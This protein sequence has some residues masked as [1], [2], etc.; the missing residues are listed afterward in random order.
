MT[1]VPRETPKIM[2]VLG[3]AGLLPFVVTAVMMARAAWF[4]EGLQSAA[5]GGFYVPYIFIAYSAV[6][7]SFL[8]GTL[9]SKWTSFQ[10]QGLSGLIIVSSNAVALISW[11]ALLLIYLSSLATLLALGLLVSGFLSLM[12]LERFSQNMDRRYWQLRVNLTIA[13]TITH[14]IVIVLMVTEL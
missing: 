9:W 6:I 3:Y 5:L 14:L 1:T 8:A 12:Y 2:I 13:V 11:I 7:L 10:N 4:G